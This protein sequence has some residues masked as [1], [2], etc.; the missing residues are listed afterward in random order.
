MGCAR[1]P[2]MTVP[3]S[4]RVQAAQVLAMALTRKVDAQACEDAVEGQGIDQDCYSHVQWAMTTGIVDHPDWYGDEL[5]PQSSFKAF[6]CALYQMPSIEHC[7]LAP[8]NFECAPLEGTRC[9]DLVDGDPC[10]Q[11]VN[12]AMATGIYQHPEWYP[13]LSVHS[14][15]EAFHCELTLKESQNEVCSAQPC[16][17]ECDG[18]YSAAA[19]G[20]ECETAV[21]GQGIDTDC[22]D[23]VTWAMTYGIVDHPEWYPE[24]RPDSSF[25]AFQC[26]L[27][28]T[29]SLEH[30]TV[31]PC[32]YDC[33]AIT[34]DRCHDLVE[35]DA[36][37]D[38]VS[39]A[40]NTGINTN[41]EWYPGMS[42][43]DS[44]EAF[45]CFLSLN[46][47]DD[48]DTLP[49]SFECDGINEAPSDPC[50][51]CTSAQEFQVRSI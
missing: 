16:Q 25:E 3:V 12:W 9:H 23:H 13:N 6:Q 37:F 45:H 27:Y 35:S 17:Y 42:P 39:W 8:C 32:F 34:G 41:P 24:L 40:M 46:D 28:L 48:C 10:M 19:G 20:D 30:C 5:T 4:W 18:V 51:S 43:D 47:I 26:H 44:F 7:T 15:F 1:R 50:P 11:H 31:A 14:D 29:T 2:A 21:E 36:C 33:P 38:H 49:C 22:F